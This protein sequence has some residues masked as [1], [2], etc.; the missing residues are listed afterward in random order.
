MC[1][2]FLPKGWHCFCAFDWHQTSWPWSTSSSI[3]AIPGLQHA[4]AVYRNDAP[5]LL[6]PRAQ[7]C[8]SLHS[9]VVYL[10][11]CW[12]LLDA[13]KTTAGVAAQYAHTT[14]A[15]QCVSAQVLDWQCCP[16]GKLQTNVP[17]CRFLTGSAVLLATCR[18]NTVKHV[19]RHA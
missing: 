7:G 1:H 11:S 16:V 4:V 14:T 5:M 10:W 8:H 17:L 6:P 19:Q 15:N 2:P 18:L 13:C 12:L 9:L 3:T